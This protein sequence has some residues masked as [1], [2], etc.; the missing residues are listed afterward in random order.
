MKLI[1]PLYKPGTKVWYNG[2]YYTVNHVVINKYDLYLKLEELDTT[3]LSDK[4]L[5]EPTVL[6]L[7]GESGDRSVS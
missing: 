6:E 1:L 5:L 7:R 3:I 2:H 4:V